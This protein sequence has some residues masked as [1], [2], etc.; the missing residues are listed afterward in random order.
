MNARIEDHSDTKSYGAWLGREVSNTCRELEWAGFFAAADSSTTAKRV[1]AQPNKPPYYIVHDNL[2]QEDV[3]QH[4]G[5]ISYESGN[6]IL[7]A[8]GDAQISMLAPEGWSIV[9]INPVHF[10]GEASSTAWGIA[11]QGNGRQDAEKH[12]NSL[13]VAAKD[14]V[15]EDGVESAFIKGL[16]SFLDAYSTIAVSAIEDAKETGKIPESIAA[17]MSRFFGDV[18][19]AATRT[20]RFQLLSRWLSDQ[21][22]IVRDGAAIGLG[23]FGGHAALDRLRAAYEDE[24]VAVI[25][26]DLRDLI[27]ALAS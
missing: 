11:L 24:L 16:R 2:T 20:Q 8:V 23:Y 25:R 19:H 13:I 15:F 22:V 10:I 17:E 3:L 12:L 21:S 27:E 9:D 6:I 7:C 18:D 14:E 4:I 26:D 5:A 1:A